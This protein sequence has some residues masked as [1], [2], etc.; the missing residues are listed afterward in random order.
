ML[1]E[2]SVPAELRSLARLG[3]RTAHAVKLQRTPFFAFCCCVLESTSAVEW[4]LSSPR[5]LV[6]QAVDDRSCA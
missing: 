3:W 5:F 1:L 4:S 6:G 2:L